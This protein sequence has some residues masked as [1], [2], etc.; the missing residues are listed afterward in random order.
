[1]FVLDES[2]TVSNC[3]SNMKAGNAKLALDFE[4][5]ATLYIQRQSEPPATPVICRNGATNQPGVTKDKA[6]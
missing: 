2:Y 4:A 5:G 1:M 3:Y 6:C